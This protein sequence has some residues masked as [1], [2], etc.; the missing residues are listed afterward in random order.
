MGDGWKLEKN[1]WK[2]DSYFQVLTRGSGCEG[3]RAMLVTIMVGWVPLL[4]C[5]QSLLYKQKLLKVQSSLVWSSLGDSVTK[6]ACQ[7][8]C[9]LLERVCDGDTM[10]VGTDNEG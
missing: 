5:R 9:M 1:G 8:L 2:P 3:I 7:R 6:Y 4:V 10:C